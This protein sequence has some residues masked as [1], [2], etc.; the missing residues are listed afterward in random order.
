MKTVF[1]GVH[2]PT[3]LLRADER[4]GGMLARNDGERLAGLMSDCTL[5]DLPGVSHLIHWTQTETTLRL[6]LGF[7]ESL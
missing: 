2:C 4:S 1:S 3:L 7:L 6:V 5:I